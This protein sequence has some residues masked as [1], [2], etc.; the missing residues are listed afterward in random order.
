MATQAKINVADIVDSSKIGAFHIAIGALCGM[1][2][3][4]DGFDVQAMGY[5]APA[6][7]RDWGIAGP[8]LGPVFSAGLFG[9]LVGSLVFSTV[10]DKVGR[11][12]M[13]ITATFFFSILTFLTGRTNS[14]GELLAVRFIAGMGLFALARISAESKIKEIGIRKVNGASIVKIMTML[15]KSYLKWV[16]VA[17]VI[18]CPV[19]WY[20]LH[21]WLQ[22]FAFKT[23]LSWW[24]F[25]AAGAITLGIA[26]IT[27]SWQSWRAA[28]RNPVEALRYE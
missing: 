16:T 15:N 6:L 20:V 12:P 24:I 10:A 2:L 4:I 27:V 8:A 19:A 17:F 23:D 5:T 7:I 1:C 11:R 9:I 13:L 26:V 28:T 3:M 18:A 22:N 21:K 14:I 25:I